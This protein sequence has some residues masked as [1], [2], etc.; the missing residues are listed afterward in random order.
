MC[1]AAMQQDPDIG[2]RE[3]AI[4]DFCALHKSSRNRLGGAARLP[5]RLCKHP[6]IRP[7]NISVFVTDFGWTGAAA[8]S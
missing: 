6:P 3:R 2:C 1:F 4:K 5:H 7:S 8:D